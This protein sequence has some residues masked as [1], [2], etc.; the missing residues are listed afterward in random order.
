MVVR[1]RGAGFGA[2][3]GPPC[4]GTTQIQQQE[5]H[6]S[7]TISSAL[8]STLNTSAQHDFS[9]HSPADRLLAG[10][11]DSRYSTLLTFRFFSLSANT[12]AASLNCCHCGCVAGGWRW[13][14]EGGWRW[15][16]VGLLHAG[17]DLSTSRRSPPH[18]S[19]RLQVTRLTAGH[20]AVFTGLPA[21]LPAPVCPPRAQGQ[22]EPQPAV[23]WGAASYSRRGNAMWAPDSSGSS[24]YVPPSLFPNTLI[25]PIAPTTGFHCHTFPRGGCKQRPMDVL[26]RCVGA[27]GAAGSGGP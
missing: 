26:L 5:Q 12:V 24:V 13:R 18:V 2:A 22:Q 10:L 14:M 25:L 17:V 4:G 21:C 6:S 16:A 20:G 11:T 8:H 7:N 15:R 19:Q 3:L 9:I 23:G 1:R 27:V